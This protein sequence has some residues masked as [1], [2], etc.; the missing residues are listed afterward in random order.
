MN[1]KRITSI[2]LAVC[3]MVSMVTQVMPYAYA[4]E[5]PPI[6]SVTDTADAPETDEESHEAESNDPVEVTTLEALLTALEDAQ[7]NDTIIIMGIIEIIPAVVVGT[8]DKH[9]TLKKGTPTAYF[10]LS[11]ADDVP[12][13]VFRNMTFDGDDILSNMPYMCTSHNVEFHNVTF[14]NCNSD[15]PGGAVFVANGTTNFTD[16]VFD[17]NRSMQGGHIRGSN[18]TVNI[19]NCIFTNGYAS[20]GGGALFSSNTAFHIKDSTIKDN[21][22]GGVG[23]GVLASGGNMTIERTKI[24]NNTAVDGG[25]DIAFDEWVM[26]VLS[27]SLDDLVSMYASDGIVPLGWFYDYNTTQ[28][29]NIPGMVR[30]I[31]YTQ[32]KLKF[33][34]TDTPDNFDDADDIDTPDDTDDTN[35]L[36]DLNTPDNPDSTND[37]TPTDTPDSTNNNTRNPSTGGGYVSHTPLPAATEQTEEDPKTEKVLSCGDAILDPARRDY[38]LGYADSQRGENTVISRARAVQVLYQIL[39]PDSLKNVYSAT[40]GFTDVSK[41]DWY[42]EIV[43]TLKNAG[44]IS[45]CGNEMF[46]PERG[47]TYAE[48]ITILTRFTEPRTDHIIP[49]KHWSSGA[50]NTAVSLEWIEYN[51]SLDPD[52]EV[53]TQEYI[54][55]IITVFDWISTT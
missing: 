10:S 1:T 39:T 48:M 18:S 35:D 6:E 44:I 50:I 52:I 23:G 29:I 43:S 12:F 21:S 37:P 25:S 26:L 54:D 7:D 45:G 31:N 8:D 24:Y 16:C 22:A 28:A 53:T 27:D 47:L 42:F 41:D 46:Q 5:L 17:N 55:F 11:Y 33:E 3:L 51:D 9:V 34:G 13:T 2:L 49:L 30:K 38:L 15:M 40:E 32:L 19:E 36:D 4:E 20:L 14:V